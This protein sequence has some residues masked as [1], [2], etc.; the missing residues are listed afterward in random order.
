MPTARKTL[1]GVARALFI[2]RRIQA[3]LAA[4]IKPS[5][6]NRIPTPMRKSANAMD[7]IES[8]P[9]VSCSSCRLLLVGGQK[10]S[11]RL[12]P[13][14]C[15]SLRLR[16]GRGRSCGRG[17]FAGRIAEETEEIAVRLQQE[18]G[19]GAAQSVLIRRHRAVEGE[20]LRILAVGLGEQAVAFGVALA[21]HLLGG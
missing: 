12:T 10:R 5:S 19:V 16:R 4:N 17:R 1:S 9:P 3:G 18:A 6:T 11:F 21:A 15:R 20:E 13:V 8:E 7:L 14:N 2:A